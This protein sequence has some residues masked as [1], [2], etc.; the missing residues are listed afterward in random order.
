[1]GR[2]DMFSTHRYVYRRTSSHQNGEEDVDEDIGSKPECP[3][4][5]GTRGSLLEHV[6]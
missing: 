4:T 6:E 5:Q 1:M 2:S 3:R